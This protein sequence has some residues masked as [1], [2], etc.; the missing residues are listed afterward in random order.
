MVWV[1]VLSF[2]I[3]VV[4]WVGVTLV[5]RLVREEMKLVVL[6]IAREAVN[7]L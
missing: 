4:V 7:T 6:S 3:E 2:V 5:A 1:V